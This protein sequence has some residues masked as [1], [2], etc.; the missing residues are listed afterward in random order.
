MSEGVCVAKGG[1]V[2]LVIGEDVEGRRR[3]GACGGVVSS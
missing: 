3:G 1:G 2:R